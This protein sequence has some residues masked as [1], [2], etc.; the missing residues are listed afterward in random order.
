MLPTLLDHFDA[1][2]VISLPERKDRRRQVADE[3]DRAGCTLG[4]ERAHIVD[5]IRPPDAG[6]FP[7][8]GARGC[9]LSHLAVL[10]LARAEG[11]RHVLV[12]EDDI[13]FTPALARSAPLGAAVGV[14]DWDF[15]YPGHAEPAIEGPLRWI[16]TSTPLVCAHCY[17]VHSRAYDR[18][19][20]YLET[21]LTRPPGHPDGG[22]MHVDGAFSTLRTRERDLV[23]L[24]ASTSIAGQRASRSDIEGPTRADRTPLA[25][26]VDAARNVKNW[27]RRRSGA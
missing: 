5:G 10:R 11:T 13:M 24:R 27:W 17:A 14:G 25:P 19:I 23:T 21:C 4:N 7:S 26:L 3:L 6:G 15:L 18:V 22:P 16:P 20:D 2:R 12:L 8:V 1:I 9:F